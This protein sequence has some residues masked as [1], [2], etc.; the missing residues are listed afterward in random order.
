[1]ITCILLSS[2]SFAQVDFNF[3]TESEKALKSYKKAE[4]AYRQYDLGKTLRHLSKAI[5]EDS[6]FIEAYLLLGDVFAVQ[7]KTE[8]AIE[9]YEKAIE[10]NPDFFPRVHY[11]AGNQHFKNKSFS[12]AIKHYQRFLEYEDQYADVRQA[13]QKKIR[14]ADLARGFYE[15]PVPFNP[16][17]AGPAVNSIYNDYMNYVT[18]D[19]QYLYF[20]RT[21]PDSGRREFSENIY[22]AGNIDSTWKSTVLL[23]ESLKYFGSIGAL[24]LS[25]DG[26]YLFF[27]SCHAADGYGSCDLYYSGKKG[28]EW[29]SPRNLGDVINSSA[30]DSQPSFSSD[31]RTLYF[32][33]ARPDGHGG[34]DI[35]K[36]VLS[37]EGRWSIPQNLGLPINT[38]GEEMAPFIHPDGRTLYFS[39]DGHLGL[40]EKDL[41]VSKRQQDGTWS[42]PFNLGYP[43][44][45]EADEINIIVDAAGN[46]GYISTD[47]LGGYGKKDIYFFDLY[48]SIRP[49]PVTYMKGR[50]FDAQTKQKLGAHFELIDLATEAVIVESFSDPKSGEFLVVIPSNKNYAL[51]VSKKGYLFYSDHFKLKGIYE[52]TNP[53]IKDIYLKPIKEGESIVLKNI[54][55]DYD[56]YELK[57]ESI[58]EL[59]KAVEFLKNN[60]SLYVEIGGHT[61]D[62]GSAEY[63]LELS[64][65]RAKSVYDYLVEYGITPGRLTYK[66]YGF[67]QPIATNETEE[68]RARNRRTEFKIVRVEK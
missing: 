32:V 38:S 27:V 57:E 52:K 59:K 21:V 25:P 56:K 61:D 22:R 58:P 60:P 53:Y 51:N 5:H 36:S 29:V 28:E 48:D 6:T 16:V 7:N 14:Q 19:N 31:G 8:R 18:A 40:G 49:E 17:N 67:E 63:N 47:K 65:Q 4:K 34:S 42:K 15:N 9:A 37:D 10:I 41:F 11:F 3:T 55:F 50:V 66:G 2:L 13:V 44:N 35:W 68:G 33:S 54:F 46:K 43:I 45:T 12:A 26:K 39:S 30:W 20:T 64:K 24:T 62:Q 23:N 1:M